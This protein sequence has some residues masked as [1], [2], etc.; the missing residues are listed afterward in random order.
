MQ[1]R[2]DDI[3]AIDFFQTSERATA[4]MLLKELGNLLSGQSSHGNTA[5]EGI[6]DLI[7]KTWV[8]RDNLFIDRIACGWLIRRFVDQ[9]A[10]FKICFGISI[11][12]KSQ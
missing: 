12:P 3:T 7:G 5:R 9:G 11:F 10:V 4:E 1:R 2:L 6:G 8:T